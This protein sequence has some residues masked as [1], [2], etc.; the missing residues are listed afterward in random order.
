VSGLPALGWS[1]PIPR[2]MHTVA[3]QW[4]DVRAVAAAAPGAVAVVVAAADC[5]DKGSVP[6]RL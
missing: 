3:E 1:G 5:V 6:L 2:N 4:A